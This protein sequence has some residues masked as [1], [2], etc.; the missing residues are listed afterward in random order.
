MRS[1]LRRTI[2]SRNTARLETHLPRSSHS[3][4]L[5]ENGGWRIMVENA[6]LLTRSRC[7]RLLRANSLVSTKYDWSTWWRVATVCRLVRRPCCWR[8]TALWPTLRELA[9]PSLGGK[10]T[11]TL[12]LRSLPRVF[13]PH[14]LHRPTSR[15]FLP[16]RMKKDTRSFSQLLR[17]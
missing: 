8:F 3:Q 16:S 9:I 4:G 12:R 11:L 15:F 6:W 17:C 1:C 10:E 13:C 7:R 5:I 2:K 14:A